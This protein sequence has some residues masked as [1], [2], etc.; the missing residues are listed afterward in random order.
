[1]A[2]LILILCKRLNLTAA[3]HVHVVEPHWNPSVEAQAI[4]RAVRMGQTKNVLVTRY[5][6]R[7]TVEEVSHNVPSWTLM[8][9]LLTKTEEHCR[10]TD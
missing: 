9:V 4:A 3:S 2:F 7:G 6:M 5:I 1:M 8:T 10:V